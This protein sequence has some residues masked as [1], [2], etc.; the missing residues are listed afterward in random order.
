MADSPDNSMD[1][2]V[3]I[4]MQLAT[5][6]VQVIWRRYAGFLALHGFIIH[7]LIP[8]PTNALVGAAIAA[9]GLFS[10]GVWYVLNFCGWLNQNAYLAWAYGLMPPRLQGSCPWAFRPEGRASPETPK[11]EAAAPSPP[12]QG[13]ENTASSPTTGGPSD[14][15]PVGTIYTLAQVAPVCAAVA[16]AIAV[17]GLTARDAMEWIAPQVFATALSCAILFLG[18]YQV[19]VYVHRRNSKTEAARR[20]A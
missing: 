4:A 10:C 2:G 17:V 20:I 7:G 19:T 6:E 3:A 18:S 14:P 5:T 15:K 8:L 1:P 13:S 9:A 11:T 16:Y 12:G